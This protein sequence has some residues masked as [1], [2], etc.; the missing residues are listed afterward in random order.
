M[1]IEQQN[2][3]G[4]AVLAIMDTRIDARVATE[5]KR[6]I[7]DV[8]EGGSSRIALDLSKVEFVDSS[9]LGA[10]VTILKMVGRNGELSIAGARDTVLDLFRL[11]RMDKVFNLY[12]T[13]QAA[14][15]ALSR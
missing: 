13:A 14:V 8:I 1:R 11:T 3:S 7:S 10:I 9:G 4:V 5:F 15:A 6:R 12:P 2:E